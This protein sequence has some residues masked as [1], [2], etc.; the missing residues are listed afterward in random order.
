MLTHIGFQNDIICAGGWL[1]KLPETE[2]YDALIALEKALAIVH[3]WPSN[4][5]TLIRFVCLARDIVAEN[6]LAELGPRHLEALA[7]GGVS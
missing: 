5:D 7:F 6:A 3:G 4:R 2:Q 1:E